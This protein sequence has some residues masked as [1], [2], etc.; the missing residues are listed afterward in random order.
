MAILR[1]WR[2]EIR[3]PLKQEHVDYV[4][5]TGLEAYR[6]KRPSDPAAVNWPAP[7]SLAS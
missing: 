1:E 7:R 4:S 2:A 6:L 5:S 3:R